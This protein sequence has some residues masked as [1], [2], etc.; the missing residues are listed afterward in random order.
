MTELPAD[1]FKEDDLTLDALEHGR[2][3]FEQLAE[4][5]ATTGQCRKGIGSLSKDDLRVVVFDRVVEEG[6]RRH[7]SR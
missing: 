2:L 1:P 7:F 3:L 4:E 5:Y 6:Q